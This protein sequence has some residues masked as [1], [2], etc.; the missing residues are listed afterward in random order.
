MTLFSPAFLSPQAPDISPGQHGFWAER[1]AAAFAVSDQSAEGW[2][3]SDHRGHSSGGN[4]P[5]K[6]SSRTA[7]RT[8]DIH[9]NTAWLVNLLRQ[10]TLELNLDIY[11]CY[12]SPLCFVSQSLWRSSWRRRRWR[13]S[14]RWSFLLTWGTPRHIWSRPEGWEVF[15]TT[16]FWPAGHATGNRPRIIR[17]GETS[18]VRDISS[19]LKVLYWHWRFHE[20]P[21]T[22]IEPLLSSQGSL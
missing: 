3:G 6:P 11:L 21:L 15:N 16:P 1:G 7:G 4:L 13:V 2:E 19:S 12:N 20:E 5:G 22:T 8:G 18:L 14:V 17:A 10:H 9:T